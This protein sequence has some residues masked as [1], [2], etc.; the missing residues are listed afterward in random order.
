MLVQ[1]GF[2]ED[3]AFDSGFP[4]LDDV[5][6]FARLGAAVGAYGPLFLLG[7]S[8]RHLIPPS[9]PAAW[10]GALRSAFAPTSVLELS[11]A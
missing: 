5:I 1:T 9:S 11:G 3:I 7:R 8:A 6:V 4:R 2:D 10:Q